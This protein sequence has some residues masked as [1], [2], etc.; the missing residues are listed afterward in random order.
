MKLKPS[1]ILLAAKQLISNPKDW[2]TKVMSRNSINQE[3][4]PSAPTACKWCAAGAVIKLTNIQDA[5]PSLLFLRKATKKWGIHGGD[6]SVAALND[7]GKH[8]DVMKLFDVAIELSL[9]DE[10]QQQK[11][12]T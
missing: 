2:T 5:E 12:T 8:E 11:K 10:E 4:I 3:V 9:Q 7:L 6:G 1:D